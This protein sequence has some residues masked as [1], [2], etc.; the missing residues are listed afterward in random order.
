MQE[1]GKRSFYLFL[2]VVGIGSFFL[3][4]FLKKFCFELPF[5]ASKATEASTCK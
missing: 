1:V 5:L 2:S 4:A 3:L